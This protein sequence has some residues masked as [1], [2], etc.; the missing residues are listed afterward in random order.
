MAGTARIPAYE[1][2]DPTYTVA[3]SVYGPPSESARRTNMQ[4]SRR[5]CA[6]AQDESVR[7]SEVDHVVLEGWIVG[8]LRFLV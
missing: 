5:F 7:R 8:I 1:Y 2:A 3:S 6:S 4:V